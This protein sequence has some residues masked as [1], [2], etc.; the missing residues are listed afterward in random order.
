M[1]VRR[2]LP[3]LSRGPGRVRGG[4]GAQA[5]RFGRE[6]PVEGGLQLAGESQQP[7]R[8]RLLAD[9]DEQQLDVG[10]QVPAVLVRIFVCDLFLHDLR[11]LATSGLSGCE[12]WP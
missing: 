1:T 12:G 2:A 4:N 10:R 3:L 7:L 5:L 11:P 9:F 8:Y 6:I